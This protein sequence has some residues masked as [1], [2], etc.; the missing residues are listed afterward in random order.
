MAKFPAQLLQISEILAVLDRQ[1]TVVDQA[2]AV[3]HILL[4]DH[5]NRGMHVP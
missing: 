2:D 1:Y 3:I 5:F 4:M